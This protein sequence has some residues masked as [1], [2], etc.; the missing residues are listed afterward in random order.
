MFTNFI[1]RF[2]DI[3]IMIGD[4]IATGIGVFVQSIPVVLSELKAMF[5]FYLMALPH[6]LLFIATLGFSK[7]IKDMIQEHNMKKVLV[8]KMQIE[9]KIRR[10]SIERWMALREQINVYDPIAMRA[11]MKA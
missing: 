9:Q 7:A 10:D 3:G 2:F 11:Y 5:L 4:K 6:V 8:A 1:R